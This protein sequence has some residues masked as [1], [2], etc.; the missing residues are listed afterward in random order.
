MS[1]VKTLYFLHLFTGVLRRI[2]V[3][4]CHSSRAKVNYWIFTAFRENILQL[5]KFILTHGLPK[6]KKQLTKITLIHP[7][8][9]KVD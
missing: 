9:V 4:E 7:T 5:S 3:K 6:K 8:A 1:K 2:H